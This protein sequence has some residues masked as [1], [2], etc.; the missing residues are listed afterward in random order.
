[1]AKSCLT[2][3]HDIHESF[4]HPIPDLVSSF[5]LFTSTLLRS[6]SPR[7]IRPVIFGRSSGLQS[8]FQF[9]PNMFNRVEVRALLQSWEIVSSF[10]GHFLSREIFYRILRHYRIQRQHIQLCPR[11]YGRLTYGCDGQVATCQW[12]S[13]PLFCYYYFFYFYIQCPR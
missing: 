8:V 5:P 3:E 2:P 11:V 9:I 1:M 7:L 12:S 4:E 10:F 6:L 13:C